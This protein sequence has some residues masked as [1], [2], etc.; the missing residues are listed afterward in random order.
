MGALLLLMLAQS[1]SAPGEVA[2]VASS[3]R[4]P[5]AAQKVVRALTEVLA[6][7]AHVLSEDAAKARLAELGGVDPVTCDGARL[8][9]SKLAELLGPHATVIGIDVARAGR[10]TSC[11][12][13]AVGAGKVDSL[14]A[15][16]FTAETKGFEARSKQW[17]R[18]FGERLQAR[19][20][21]WNAELEA[22][23][24]KPAPAPVV[25]VPAPVP[26]PE[27]VLAPPPPPPVV[28]ERPSRTPAWVST[29]VGGATLVSTGVLLGL[30][31]H[32]RSTYLSSI[33]TWRG[34]NDASGLTYTQMN[35]T[36]GRANTELTVAL[37]LGCVTAAAAT[38][39]L[40]FFTR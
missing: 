9:L 29:V 19:L 16:D 21:G 30:G 15:D 1:P 37:A 40:Y 31:L 38:L 13:E 11:H 20:S 33:A 7:N 3:R 34:P 35:D 32:D 25:V 18:S 4:E 28:E 12:I 2:V 14:L 26:T 8:C 10:F 17:A 27:P 24:P 22:A 36:V 23:R 6:P 39:A 5:A